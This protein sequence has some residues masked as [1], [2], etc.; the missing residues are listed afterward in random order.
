LDEVEDEDL[1]AVGDVDVLREL[2]V[3]EDGGRKWSV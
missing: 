2:D 1:D 3:V